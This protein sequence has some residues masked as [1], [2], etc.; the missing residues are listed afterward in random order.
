FGTD[1]IKTFEWYRGY[2][3]K[4]LDQLIASGV[5]PVVM[6]IPPYKKTPLLDSWAHTLN[7]MVRGFAEQRQIPFVDFHTPMLSLPGFG[8]APDQIHP[9]IYYPDAS[10][11]GCYFTTKGLEYGFNLRNLLTLEAFDRV[12]RAMFEPETTLDPTPPPLPD[13]DGSIEKPFVIDGFPYSDRRNTALSP[14]RVLASYS[15]CNATQ[16]ESGP[17]YVYRFEL[18]RKTRIRAIV[19]D[20]DGG[21][22]DVDLHLLAG[23]P[24]EAACLERNDKTINAELD[25]GVY[26]L[27]LDTY[28]SGGTELPGEYLL[29][30][31]RCLDDDDYC[32]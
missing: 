15:G 19:L 26:Y 11:G 23:A 4:L 10:S 28:V 14:H 6:A 25:S 27:V 8:L 7:A 16:D 18:N 17:E 3:E 12:R 32:L 22:V 2:M 21:S 29:V 13:G 20:G 31:H 5:I 9:N 24:T 30:I 1:T